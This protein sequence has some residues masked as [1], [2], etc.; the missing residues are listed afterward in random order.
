MLNSGQNDEEYDARKDHS[1]NA[2]GYPSYRRDDKT[3]RVVG[4]INKG[5]RLLRPAVGRTR[6]KTLRWKP[7]G[8]TKKHYRMHS[9][10]IG[11]N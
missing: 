11:T 2:A 1:S 10:F 9:G 7:E 8:T 5:W 3:L 4:I 6:K